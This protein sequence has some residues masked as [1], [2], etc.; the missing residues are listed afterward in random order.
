MNKRQLTAQVAK[1]AGISQAQASK[2]IN[3]TL[4]QITDTLRKGEKV[5]LAG[6]GTF[7]VRKPRSRASAPR[8][9]ATTYATAGRQAVF[10]PGAKLVRTDRSMDERWEKSFAASTHILD[11]LSEKALADFHAGRTRPLDP[12]EL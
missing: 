9:L 2:V 3:A 1:D 11:E 6:F 10:N 7:E 4:R 12:D 8:N 5:T